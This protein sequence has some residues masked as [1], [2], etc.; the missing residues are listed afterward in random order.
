M[1]VAAF[2]PDRPGSKDVCIP[3]NGRLRTQIHYITMGMALARPPRR[4]GFILD[5][6]ELIRQVSASVS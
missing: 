4:F 3:S 5:V 6:F 2:I 1:A